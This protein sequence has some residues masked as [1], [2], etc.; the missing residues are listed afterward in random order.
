MGGYCYFNNA[1]VATEVLRSEGKVAILD[2]D[3]H[4]GNGTHD[5]VKRKNLAAQGN[6]ILAISIHAD[7]D[8]MFPNFTGKTNEIPESGCVNFALDSGINNKEYDKILLKAL[9]MIDLFNPDFITVSLGFDTYK[10]DPICDFKLT[11]KYYERMAN[12]IMEVKKP[13]VIIQEG[14]YNTD[15]IGA[16]ALSFIK[17]IEGK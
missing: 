8:R 5:I 13:T 7:P 12:Q 9:S 2:V 10:K 1:M 4:H 11:T 16:N 3:F 15:A 6:T 14:G 17:G